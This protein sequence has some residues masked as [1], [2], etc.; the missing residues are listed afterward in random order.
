MTWQGKRFFKHADV[1]VEEGGYAVRLDNRPI[2]TPA[3]APLFVAS[4]ALAHAIAAE[5]QA[6]EDTI[7]PPSMPMMALATT[8]IDQVR[9]NRDTVV[10]TVV[11]YGGTDLLCYRADHPADLAVRQQT[12]WQPLLDRAEAVWGARLL[13]TRGVIPTR[14]PAETLAA[15]QAAVEQFNDLEL[16]ALASAV[17]AAGSLIVGL[18]LASGWIDADEAFEIAELDETYQIE[19]WGEDPEALRRRRGLHQEL[20]AAARFLDLVRKD[21]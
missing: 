12:R 3:G 13:H 16:T 1:S 10:A 4:R 9:G 19:R 14:Q 20:A 6:Q 18:A 17:H 21:R 11:A 8:A 2:R 15:L 7:R 5:W